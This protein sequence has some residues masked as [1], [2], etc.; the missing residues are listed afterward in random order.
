MNKYELSIEYEIAVWKNSDIRED[1]EPLYVEP[2]SSKTDLEV[3]KKEAEKYDIE[4]TGCIEIFEKYEDD[5]IL[6][7]ENGEWSEVA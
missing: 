1:G 6:H 7:F 5:A 4:P 2:I 3:I